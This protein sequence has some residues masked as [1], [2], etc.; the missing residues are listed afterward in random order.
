M[1]ANNENLDLARLTVTAAGESRE[2]RMPWG[3]TVGEVEK[4]AAEAFGIVAAPGLELWCADGTSLSN[5]LERTLGE[6]KQRRICPKR[7][8]EFRGQNR[9]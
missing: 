3:T 6:F 4:A 1:S 7:V 8:F 9:P 2:L 5:K